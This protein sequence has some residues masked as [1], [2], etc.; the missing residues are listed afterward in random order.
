[1]KKIILCLAVLLSLTSCNNDSLDQNLIVKCGQPKN[2][3]I[4]KV[5][6]CLQPLQPTKTLSTVVVDSQEKLNEVLV[7]CYWYWCEIMPLQN[8]ANVSATS[9]MPYTVINFE[10]EMVV[11]VLSGEKPS[12]GYVV[13]IESITEDD[14][15]ILV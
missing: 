14:C 12:G 13:K 15:Q 6:Y 10:K 3:P 1:M 4:V 11:A 2:I 9:V 5:N 8:K 7:P